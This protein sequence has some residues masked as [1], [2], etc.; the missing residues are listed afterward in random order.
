MCIRDRKVVEDKEFTGY[1]IVYK[2]NGKYLS[3]ITGVEYKENSSVE[4][5]NVNQLYEIHDTVYKESKWLSPNHIE[6]DDTYT[7]RT[8]V[9]RFKG[10][11]EE[12]CNDNEETL[13]K[14]TLIATEEFPLELGLF[15]ISMV[16]TGGFIGKIEE[17][18]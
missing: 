7:G 16:V 11:A 17:I 10:G 1:K 15:G 4:V 9:F 8:A 6:K 2:E 14:M 12:Y 13:V 3:P 18:D 5:L